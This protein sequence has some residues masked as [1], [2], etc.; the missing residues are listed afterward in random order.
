VV[1]RRTWSSTIRKAEATETL[2]S[3]LKFSDAIKQDF[4]AFLFG[5]VLLPFGLREFVNS[6]SL[7]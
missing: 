6:Q 3:F 2:A 1:G 7:M 5:D 4:V